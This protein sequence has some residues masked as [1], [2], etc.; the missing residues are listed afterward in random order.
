[1]AA[2][3]YTPS[4]EA[5]AAILLEQAQTWARGVRN[6]D[7]LAFVVFT[8]SKPQTIYYTTESACSCPSFFHRGACSHQLAVKREAEAARAAVGP[9]RATYAELMAAQGLVDAF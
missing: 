1:M 5:K 4:M 3:V 6:S 2:P 9:R 7:G 8:S